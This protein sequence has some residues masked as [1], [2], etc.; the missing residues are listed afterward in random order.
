MRTTTLTLTL[1]ASLLTPAQGA[2]AL[3][4]DPAWDTVKGADTS[5]EQQPSYVKGQKSGVATVKFH[6]KMKLA[7]MAKATIPAHIAEIQP[8]IKVK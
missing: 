1:A 4:K 7:D 8:D 5:Q 3:A 6:R 2:M